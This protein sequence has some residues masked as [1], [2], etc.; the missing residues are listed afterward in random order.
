M[1]NATR[2]AD[3]EPRPWAR[4]RCQRCPAGRSDGGIGIGANALAVSRARRG[5]SRPQGCP[6]EHD[7]PAEDRRDSEHASRRRT[8]AQKQGRP[9]SEHRGRRPARDRVDQ[10]EVPVSVRPRQAPVVR[11]VHDRARAHQGPHPRGRRPCRHQGRDEG[12][13]TEQHRPRRH[14]HPLGGALEHQVP[15]G[16]QESC[17]Q[18]QDEG[19]WG[20]PPGGSI[21]SRARADRLFAE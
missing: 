8:L 1:K 16:V 9:Q 17:R 19:G 20:H 4:N 21:A 3:P 14:R 13:R 7:Q 11:H 10:R 6:A 5:Q 15:R 18:D 2:K 12:H